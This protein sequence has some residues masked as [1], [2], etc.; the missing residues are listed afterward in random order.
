MTVKN[1]LENHV[2]GVRHGAIQDIFSANSV[3]VE[4][5]TAKIRTAYLE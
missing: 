1:E 4:L 2:Q 5:V 3:S